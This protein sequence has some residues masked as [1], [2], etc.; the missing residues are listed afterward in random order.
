MRRETVAMILATED[1]GPDYDRSC[2]K[3]KEKI[4]N[5]I[6]KVAMTP[7]GDRPNEEVQRGRAERTAPGV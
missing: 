6:N 5:D 2:R 7:L 3:E 4:R 1:K